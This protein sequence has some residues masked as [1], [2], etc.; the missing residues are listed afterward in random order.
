MM[1]VNVDKVRQW[2]ELREQADKLE[3]ELFGHIRPAA[4]IKPPKPALKPAVKGDKTISD[5]I[6]ETL[7][8]FGP[9]SL[10]DLSVVINRSRTNTLGCMAYMTRTGEIVRLNGDIYALAK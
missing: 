1:Q 2:L 5:I 3:A 8:T 4:E 7:K 6:R 9:T 10:T